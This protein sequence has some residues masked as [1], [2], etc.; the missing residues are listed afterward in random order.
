MTGIAMTLSSNQRLSNRLLVLA[1]GFSLS[2]S[3]AAAAGPCGSQARYPSFCS[4]P[5]IPRD[6][7]AAET[8]KTA[9]VDTRLSGRS[10]EQN[11]DASQFSLT[12]TD[13]FAADARAQATPPPSAD[14]AAQIDTAAFL[15]D[16]RARVTPP[17]RP[18]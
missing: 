10:L 11:T 8:F 3:W 17:P 14:G 18:R 16:A 1:V 6:V 5:Q 15:R 4:I 12:G 9:V 2:A 13:N 7:P